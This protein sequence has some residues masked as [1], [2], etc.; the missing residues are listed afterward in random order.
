VPMAND[1]LYQNAPLVEV[2][3]EFRWDIQRIESLPTAAIDPHFP[4]FEAAISSRLSGEGFGT[5][6][7]LAPPNVPIELLANRVLRRFRPQPNQWPVFQIGPGLFTVN[8]TPPYGGWA[9]FRTL[10]AQGLNSLLASYPMPDVYL[11]F[12]QFELKYIDAFTDR[13]G[14]RDMRSFLSD[15]MTVN[16]T[17]P[18]D[19]W[20]QASD[21]GPVLIASEISLPLKTPNGSRG[22]IRLGSGQANNQDAV[23]LELAVQRIG[24]L[25]DR[26]AILDWM[27]GAHSTVR[28]WFQLLTNQRMKKMMG[29]VKQL[30]AP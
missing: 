30:R 26:M 15:Y 6:E 8:M 18:P 27:D 28:S 2:I 25:P 10:L 11:H 5:I 23:V 19:L 29:P 9:R 16:I 4:I 13:H 21:D 20:A 7:S 17:A 14:F 22:I 12:R 1:F 24:S 3:A